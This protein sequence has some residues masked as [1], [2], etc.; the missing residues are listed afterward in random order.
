MYPKPAWLNERMQPLS[1]SPE[2]PPEKKTTHH[3]RRKWTTQTGIIVDPSLPACLSK[4]MKE[5]S[6][7]FWPKYQA[8]TETK[9]KKQLHSPCQRRL[10]K[11]A[12]LVRRGKAASCRLRTSAW[13]TNLLLLPPYLAVHTLCYYYW[14]WNAGGGGGNCCT[15]EGVAVKR[16]LFFAIVFAFGSN[17][18]KC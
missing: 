4:E 2:Y 16:T 9:K 12:R 15:R 13:R 5:G 3:C 7:S 1:S 6:L 10:G 17:S 18:C 14:S 11:A 8:E